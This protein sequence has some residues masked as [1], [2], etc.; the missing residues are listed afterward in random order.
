MIK[1]KFSSKFINLF[2]H[3][4]VSNMY[5]LLLGGDDQR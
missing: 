5:V 4:L 1:V 2:P 3:V